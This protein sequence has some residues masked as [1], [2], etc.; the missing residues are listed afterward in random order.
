[1][2]L[3]SDLMKYAKGSSRS[4]DTYDAKKKTV[5]ELV[6]LLAQRNIQVRKGNQLRLKQLVQYGRYL[7]ARVANQE[8]QPRTAINRLSHVR[9]MLRNQGRTRLANCE[10]LH[11]RAFGLDGVSRKG[12][13]SPIR[14]SELQKVCLRAPDHISAAIQVQRAFGLRLKETVMGC[15][16]EQLTI[17]LQRLHHD[18]HV[19]VVRGTKGGRTR[20]TYFPSTQMHRRAVW[21]VTNALVTLDKL[22]RNSL[23][24]GKSR[25][26]KS[27]LWS[28]RY[29]I[30]EAGLTKAATGVTSHSLRYAWS[31]ECVAAIMAD[32]VPKTHALALTSTFLGHGD[33]RGKWV[34]SVYLQSKRRG[35]NLTTDRRHEARQR[36]EFLESAA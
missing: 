2:S 29:H 15:T 34:N 36:S 7:Q 32:N 19:L 10:E 33:G 17:W 25:N 23:I 26:L 5:R 21:A 11:N 22:K 27:A 3:K 30:A 18:N 31:R 20:T 4:K 16:R 28:Y 6:R 13:N 1:M 14:E 35:T 24:V 9:T 12:T 8:I